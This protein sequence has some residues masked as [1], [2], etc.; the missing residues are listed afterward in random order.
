MENYL[1]IADDF[2]GANDTGVQVR[3]RGI[4]VRV[5][6]SGAQISGGQSAVLDTE[7][8]G[9]SAEAAAAKITA[10]CAAVPFERFDFVMKKVDSTL[11][12]NIGA[13][14]RS[15]AECFNAELIVFAP[16]LPDLG[17]TTV[18]GVHLLNGIPVSQTEL[19]RDPKTPVR[20]DNIT[21]LLRAAFGE[22][23][24]HIGAQAV[25]NN[26][27]SLEGGRIFTFD[28]ASNQDMKNIIAAALAEKKRVLWAGSAAMADNL[29]ALRR[30]LPPALGIVASLSSISRAQIHY[31]EKK[32]VAL[33]MVPLDEALEKKHIIDEITSQARSLLEDGKDVIVLSASTYDAS[34]HGKAEK[35]AARSGLSGEQMS[36]WTARLMGEISLAVLSGMSV[37]GVLLAG[38]D[39][40]MSFFGAAGSEG[41]SIETEIA[42]GIPLLRLCGG[43]FDGLK[44]VTKA[45]AFGN[46]DAIFYG[47]R[48]LREA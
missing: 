11:R 33:V 10:G 24:T 2:T 43:A 41:S 27:I 14:I 15:L 47:L 38:G 3:R 44:V 45:G 37:S 16:A 6:F 30:S 36:E 4:E 40:A 32:G 12:G 35:A 17:R 18:D 8:R 5:V 31:A 19:A 48:K 34:E 25:R 7:S 46:E 20:E 42:T 28:A 21:R 26:A 13:E 1:I 22:P 39:T 9:L 29:L 23:V